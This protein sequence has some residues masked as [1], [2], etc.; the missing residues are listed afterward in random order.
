MNKETRTI[1]AKSVSAEDVQT[2]KWLEARLMSLG[3][4][5]DT[6]YWPGSGSVSVQVSY[7][8]GWHWDE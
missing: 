2:R 5:V 3:Y 6:S 7:F 8:K 1:P 4:K